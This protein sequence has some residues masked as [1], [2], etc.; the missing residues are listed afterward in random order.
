MHKKLVALLVVF[1]VGLAALIGWVCF[2]KSPAPP[3]LRVDFL[4]ETNASGTNLA[5]FKISNPCPFQVKRW[6]IYQIEARSTNSLVGADSPS[7]A[8]I[9]R[10]GQSE[11]VAL[12]VPPHNGSWRA[13]FFCS[14][15]SVSQKLR[16]FVAL[17]KAV[18]ATMVHASGSA[19]VGGS[20]DF[21]YSDWIDP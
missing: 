5:L 21:S 16:E 19:T 7:A 4:G 3:K 2:A 1:T 17:L 11:T 13:V 8:A 15:A 12:I 6:D 14:H 18:V 10:S 20:F 9:L